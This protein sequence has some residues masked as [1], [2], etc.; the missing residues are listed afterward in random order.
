MS[1]GKVLPFPRREIN[2]EQENKKRIILEKHLLEQIHSTLNHLRYQQTTIKFPKMSSHIMSKVRSAPLPHIRGFAKVDN[3]SP[4]H[5]LDA[6]IYCRRLRS[7]LKEQ[8]IVLREIQE[9]HN[10]RIK[11]FRLRK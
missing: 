11:K 8:E 3:R 1:N 10:Q 2:R 7:T 6:A 9:Q 5:D 4:I